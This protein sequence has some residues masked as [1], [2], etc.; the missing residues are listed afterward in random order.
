M[1][2]A[3][4]INI[5]SLKSR[6]DIFMKEN[7]GDVDRTVRA[8]FGIV[9]L[10]LGEFLRSHVGDAIGIVLLATS[11][12]KCCPLYILFNLTTVES[13]RRVPTSRLV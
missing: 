12:F 4:G 10:M 7:L 13:A 9:I 1:M 3:T 8:T 6:E 5:A 11:T 2:W